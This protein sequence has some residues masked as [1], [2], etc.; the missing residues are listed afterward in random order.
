ME[1]LFGMKI[2]SVMGRIRFELLCIRFLSQPWEVAT[3]LFA[4]VVGHVRYALACRR[5]VNGKKKET[6]G[7]FYE[8]FES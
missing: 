5:L 8:Y 1:G 2:F 7:S 4:P 6:G 3:G